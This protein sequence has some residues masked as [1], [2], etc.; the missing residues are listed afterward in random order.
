MELLIPAG[1]IKHIELALK[2]KPDAVYGGFKKFNARHKAIN[3]S[4][5]DYNQL[6]KDLHNKNIKFYLTINILLLDEE[7]NEI[8]KLFRD[9]VAVLPDAFIVADVGLALILKRYFPCVPLH[10]STQFGAHNKGDLIFLEYLKASRVILARE[11]T[12]SEVNKLRN[13][14]SLELECFVWGTQCLSFSGLCFFNSLLNCGSANRGKCIITCR[15]IYN[16]DSA[17]GHLLYVPDMDAINIVS[18]LDGI[19][20]IKLEGRRRDAKELEAVINKI[21]NG[22]ESEENRG[23]LYGESVDKNNLFEIVNSR[24]KPVFRYKDLININTKDIFVQFKDNIPVAFT[25]RIK[26]AGAYY[27]YSEFK[28][29]FDVN[30]KNISFELKIE[31]GIVVEI[32]Y[33]NHRGEGKNFCI[34]KDGDQINFNIDYFSN[35]IT[36][37]NNRINVYKIWYKRNTDDKY[38][39]SRRMLSEIL[40]Y[41]KDDCKNFNYKKILIEK[42]P[43]KKLFVETNNLKVVDLLLA[44]E[45]VKPIYNIDS[46]TK[47]KNIKGTVCKYGEKIIYKL[48]LF[49]WKSEDFYRYLGS[50]E[51]KDVMFTRFS[52]IYLSNGIK[53]KSKLVDYTVYIWNKETLNLL[54]K[55]SITCFTATPELS[56]ERNVSILKGQEIQFIIGGKLPLL[57]SRCCFSHLFNCFN[58]HGSSKKIVKNHDKEMDFEILCAKDSRF[59]IYK[60][61]ILNNYKKVVAYGKSSFRYVT[62]GQTLDEIKK[63]VEMFKSDYYFELMKKSKIWEK[64]YENNILENRI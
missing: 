27:V 2:I 62:Y 51:G 17:K 21:K 36:K 26:R 9:G 53:F 30:K 42:T 45:F 52:Q 56:H 34:K 10:F 4:V 54:K 8:V 22:Q 40:S 44:D 11:L 31:G 58:C 59:M 3:F 43:I 33:L 1:N 61:P 57:Y 6:I 63:S 18:Q 50:L 20:C 35:K 13:N 29:R 23:F 25:K 46:F 49:N 55:Y 37:L 39:I 41:V 60:Y 64:S 38:T 5:E 24:I 48:P 19:N 32:L 16:V 28:N 47:L 12:L 7:I 15:D 14:T